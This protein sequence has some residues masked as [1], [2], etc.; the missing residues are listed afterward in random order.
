MIVVAKCE[1]SCISL[2]ARNQRVFLCLALRAGQLSLLDS[3]VNKDLKKSYHRAW[4]WNFKCP[5]TESFSCRT[6]DMVEPV[7]E[8]MRSA[9]VAEER[10]TLSLHWLFLP[11]GKEDGEHVNQNPKCLLTTVCFIYILKNK[12]FDSNISDKTCEMLQMNSL[13]IFIC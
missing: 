1:I 12:D 6:P 9:K 7:G 10:A 8:D 13:S 2:S 3:R 11:G 4:W 5:W